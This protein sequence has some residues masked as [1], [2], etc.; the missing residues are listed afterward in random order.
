MATFRNSAS[1][2]FFEVIVKFLQLLKL[3]LDFPDHSCVVSHIFVWF[4]IQNLLHLGLKI[5]HLKQVINFCIFP[6]F[7][8]SHIELFEHIFFQKFPNI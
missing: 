1:A 8:I 2:L 6:K 7:T 4:D 3:F 5:L